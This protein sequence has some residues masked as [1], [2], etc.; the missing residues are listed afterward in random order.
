MDI[1]E[2]L[3][4]YINIYILIHLLDQMEPGPQF[5]EGVGECI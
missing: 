2:I 5:S 3:W 1:Y 4:S